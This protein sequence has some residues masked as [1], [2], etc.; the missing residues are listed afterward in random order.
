[1]EMERLRQTHSKDLESKEDEVEEI[2]QSSSK[3]VRRW[4]CI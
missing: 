2:R 3:K 1:M 4:T